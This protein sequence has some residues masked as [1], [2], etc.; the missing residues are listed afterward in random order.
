MILAGKLQGG[1]CSKILWSDLDQ[2]KKKT[3]LTRF[4]ECQTLVMGQYKA[5]LYQ[6]YH[7]RLILCVGIRF[8]LTML[9]RFV[10]HSWPENIFGF[11]IKRIALFAEK[12]A[13]DVFS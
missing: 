8:K 10:K 2:D 6:F 11:N 3:E 5:D 4:S 13:F 7:L 12:R 9:P 1:K